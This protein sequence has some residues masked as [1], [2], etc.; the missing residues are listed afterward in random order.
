MEILVGT[1]DL[2]SGGTRYTPKKFIKHEEFDRPHLANDIGLILM[3][4]IVLNEKVQ[5]IKYSKKFVESGTKLLA[6]GW[7]V[8]NVIFIDF[9]LLTFLKSTE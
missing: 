2:Q 9:K 1:N 8:L 6:T 3:D 4:D 5:P 7:G